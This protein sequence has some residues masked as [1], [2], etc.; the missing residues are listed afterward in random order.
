MV[1]LVCTLIQCAPPS[2][3]PGSGAEDMSETSCPAGVGP[4]SL[5]SVS[6][7]TSSIHPLG[8]GFLAWSSQ[9]LLNPYSSHTLV[10]TLHSLLPEQIPP[11]L[12]SPPPPPPGFCFLDRDGGGSGEV[13]TL[14]LNLYRWQGC[15]PPPSPHH[16]C[17][18][19]HFLPPASP[20]FPAEGWV[21]LSFYLQQYS[22]P[23]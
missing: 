17:K 3:C 16:S 19:I 15:C 1:L 4:A 20:S 7:S 2:S 23:L 6:S 21:A 12:Q 14:P 13:E 11:P 9:E 10:F 18:N 5:H 22:S 8:S